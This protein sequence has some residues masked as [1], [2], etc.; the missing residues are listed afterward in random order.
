[1]AKINCWEFMKCGR[2]VGGKYAKDL[3][4]C[5][6]ALEKKADGIHGGVN[7]GR[8]CWAIAG[9]YCDGKTQ[10]TFAEKFLSCTGCRFYIL[11]CQEEDKYLISEEIKKK[12]KEK[13]P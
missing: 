4:V 13:N 12:I 3:G 2:E 8:C 9:T 1:M 6:V 7:A 10:G 5:P 11:V